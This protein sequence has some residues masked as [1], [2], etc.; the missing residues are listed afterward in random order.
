MNLKQKLII[1]LCIGLLPLLS[2]NAWN[3]KNAKNP[4]EIEFKKEMMK[5]ESEEQLK[6]TLEVTFHSGTEYPF[7]NEYAHN[8]EEGI[9]IDKVSTAPVFSSLDKYD[10]GTGW[11]SFTR[12]LNK[13]Y[14]IE[15][16]DPDGSGR[17]EVR[18]KFANV[19]FGH[20]FPDGPKPTGMRY[21]MNSA[22]LVF[23]P[24][25]KLKEKGYGEYLKLFEAKK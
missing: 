17:K 2:A 9:Y 20:V 19:H 25:S 7:R 22:S 13:E 16:Q 14:I 24:K 8:K 6:T 4:S 18:S 11:P 3:V 21:C 1:T 12:P 5:S 10:S 15:K 23:I